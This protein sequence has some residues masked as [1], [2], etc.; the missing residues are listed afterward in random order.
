MV[1][2]GEVFRRLSSTLTLNTSP[3]KGWLVKKDDGNLKCE[4][5]FLSFAALS[6]SI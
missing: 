5:S 6:V 2:L 4:K 1:F 3:K